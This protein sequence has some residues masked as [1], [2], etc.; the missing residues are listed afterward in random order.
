MSFFTS[1]EKKIHMEAQGFQISKALFGRKSDANQNT[2]YQ[3]ISHSHRTWA[4]AAM[5]VG[6]CVDS[7]SREEDLEIRSHSH[8]HLFFFLQRGQKHTL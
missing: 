8:S 5:G 2:W 1:T 6:G 7:W 3:T 4:A